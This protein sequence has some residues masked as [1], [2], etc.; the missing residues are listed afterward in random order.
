MFQ[1]GGQLIIEAIF[2]VLLLFTRPYITKSGNWINIVIQVVRV[3]SVICV[4]VFVEQF[5]IAQTT[6]TV[7]GVV[8][9]AVQASLTGVLAILIAINAIIVCCKTNPHRRR[10]KEAEKLRELDLTP[11]DPRNSILLSSDNL[12]S[13][14]G[15][16]YKMGSFN[17]GRRYDPVPN[18]YGDDR[19]GYKDSMDNLVSSAARMGVSNQSGPGYRHHS[20]PDDDWGYPNRRAV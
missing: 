12:P 5:G 11:L 19:A 4:L 13:T 9:I 17:K 8:L 14:K 1:A 6:K 2:L 20:P 15:N 7:T 3:I 10:R 16:T 18:V